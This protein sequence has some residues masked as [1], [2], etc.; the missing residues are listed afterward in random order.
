MATADAIEA[1]L[2]D[3]GYDVVRASSSA[4]MVG[5]ANPDQHLRVKGHAACV[6]PGF[7]PSMAMAMVLGGDGTVLSATRMTAPI[8][9]PS[10]RSTPAIWAFWPKPI[11]PNWSRPSIR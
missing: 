5:F 4:G 2:R 3:A 10:S 8:D 1:R 9:V 11:C 6:P 7:D